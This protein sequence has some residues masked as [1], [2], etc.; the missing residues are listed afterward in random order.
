M[1]VTCLVGGGDEVSGKKGLWYV[2]VCMSMY[3]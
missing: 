2:Y 3:V 1:D